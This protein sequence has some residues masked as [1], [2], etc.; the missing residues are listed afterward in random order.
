MVVGAGPRSASIAADWGGAV[1]AFV[2]RPAFPICHCFGADLAYVEPQA[3]RE[4]IAPEVPQRFPS[5]DSGARGFAGFS[6]DSLESQV[7]RCSNI[8]A[9]V[10]HAC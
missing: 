10:R 1:I 5:I 3:V 9:G 7:G 8:Q 4:W 6:D 2:A